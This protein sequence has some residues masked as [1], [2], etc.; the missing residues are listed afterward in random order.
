M[1]ISASIYSS[2][3]QDLTLLVRQLEELS[4]DMFH[5]DCNDQL[6][7]F[8]DIAHIQSMSSMPIDLHVICSNIDPYIPIINESNIAQ[9][10]FQVESLTEGFVIPHFTNTK[11]GLAIKIGN[12]EIY[13]LLKKHLH[14]IDFVLLMTT[15][16]GQSGGVFSLESFAMIR[17]LIHEFPS[18]KWQIDGGINH[19]I[20]YILR[21]YGVESIV[22]GNYLM[23]HSSMANAMLNLRSRMVHSDFLVVD[24]MYPREQLPIVFSGTSST[25]ELLT[26]M[27]AYRW[28]MVFC[29]DQNKQFVGIV[30]NAD[31]R[32][33]LLKGS[34]N[35]DESMDRYIN[36]D[37]KYIF[38]TF[39]TQNM[40]DYLPSVPF[41][42]LVLP[43]LNESKELVGGIS[44]HHLIKG[45]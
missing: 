30:T 6:S 3:E 28:G 34:F 15:T 14:Q 27:D 12:P 38:D 23:G 44:F 21:L 42:I 18:L 2:K 8:E 9:V 45:N 26:T 35:L 43:I 25:R 40:L 20:G 19:E 22:I 10:S 33:E 36:R 11:V 16:P 39:S 5:I 32:K 29:E 31:V 37:P 7:V 17:N 24:F 4:V 13:S 1:K 41:P